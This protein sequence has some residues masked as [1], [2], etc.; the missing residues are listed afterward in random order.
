MIHKSLCEPTVNTLE[1][2]RMYREAYDEL[3]KNKMIEPANHVHQLKSMSWHNTKNQQLQSTP[4]HSQRF[5]TSAPVMQQRSIIE[6]FIFIL[7]ILKK[8]K[9][10]IFN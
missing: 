6:F 3:M 2:T 7:I 5:H 4:G 9:F 1:L 8:Y 10:K